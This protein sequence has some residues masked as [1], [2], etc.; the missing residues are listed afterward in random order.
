M[1]RAAGLVFWSRLVHRRALHVN[2]QRTDEGTEK[3]RRS[4]ARYSI[5]YA[6][7]RAYHWQHALNWHCSVATPDA[8]PPPQLLLTG[9]GRFPVAKRTG[10]L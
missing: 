1:R 3:G 4:P 5:V 6:V 10:D 7:R 8:K 2:A 9:T